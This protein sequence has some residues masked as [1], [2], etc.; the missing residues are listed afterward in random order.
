MISLN[1][2]ITSWCVAIYSMSNDCLGYIRISGR[3]V[4]IPLRLLILYTRELV[5]KNSLNTSD[6]SLLSRTKVITYKC[7]YTRTRYYIII[8]SLS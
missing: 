3:K 2:D 6:L 8:R 7:L 5:D 1:I 4:D